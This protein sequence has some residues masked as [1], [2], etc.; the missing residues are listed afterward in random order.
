MLL[1]RRTK[2]SAALCSLAAFSVLPDAAAVHLSQTGSGQVLIFPYYTTRAS[3]V[4]NTSGEFNTVFAITNGTADHKALKV[5]FLESRNG[6]EIKDMNVFLRPN[7][8]WT[9]A[10]ISTATGARIVTNDNSCVTPGDLFTRA[11]ADNFSDANFTGNNADFHGASLDRTREGYFEVIEMGVITNTV[12]H[13]HMLPTGSGVPSNCSAVHA[14]D[15]ANGGNTADFPFQQLAAQTGGLTGRA[16]IINP[17]SGINFTYVPT[18]L[19]GWTDTVRYGGV[20][21]GIPTLGSATPPVSNI[22]LAN[23]DQLRSTW[24]TGIDAVSAVLLRDSMRSEYIND[25]GTASRTDW[26]LT[27]PTKREL[28]SAIGSKAPFHFLAG[29]HPSCQ[30]QLINV[31]FAAYRRDSVE[32]APCSSPFPTVCPLPPPALNP[33]DICFAASVIPLGAVSVVGSRSTA[34]LRSPANTFVLSSNTTAGAATSVPGQVQGP[35]GSLTLALTGNTHRMTPLSSTLNGQSIP[36]RTMIGVPMV[37]FGIHSYT[38]SGV[39]SNYGG[40]IPA[41][42]TISPMNL[43]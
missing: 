43:Q 3:T 39:V 16:S 1:P 18:A 9:A 24:A 2:L 8:M 29:A 23:G 28:I 34:F 4:P 15:P 14:L 5:R 25:V 36:V 31:G 7:D 26:I 22:S 13:G 17:E 33:S 20:G 42:Y 38:R 12:L 19:D 6:R 40:V 27:L 37:G 11:G 32:P 41:T 21:T 10:I 30:A 35:N